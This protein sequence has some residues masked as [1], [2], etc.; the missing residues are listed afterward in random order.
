MKK[1]VLITI[2]APDACAVD[3]IPA[4]RHAISNPVPYPYDW[5]ITI[6]ETGGPSPELIISQVLQGIP[7]S[8]AESTAAFTA[9][10]IHDL[11]A[12]GYAIVSVSP[13]GPGWV[14]LKQL[15]TAV[16]Q[17]QRDA[18]ELHG[19]DFTDGA[20]PD[21]VCGCGEPITLFEGAWL[22]IINPELRGTDDHDA[23]PDDPESVDWSGYEDEDEEGE[24]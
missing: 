22:H 13:D 10:V 18:E 9:Q 24:G 3:I 14:T 11:S 7:F 2:T 5:D 19:G 15:N 23:E 16:N 6:T 21:A 17:A 8:G 12:S 4:L 20:G 1:T